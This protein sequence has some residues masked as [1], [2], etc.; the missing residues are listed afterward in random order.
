MAKPIYQEDLRKFFKKLE[1]HGSI[2]D[3]ALFNIMYWC[4]LRASEIG[5]LYVESYR[6]QTRTIRIRRLKNGISKTIALDKKRARALEKYIKTLDHP[7]PDDYLFEGYKGLP[8][9]R[10]MIHTLAK[11]YFKMAKINNSSH[12]FRHSIAVHLLDAGVSVE[13]VKAHLGHK[14]I[15]NTMKY[16]EFSAFQDRE[17]TETMKNSKYIV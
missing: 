5:L 2:R 1:T 16:C 8:I 11:K 4:G 15:N 12:A 10:Q 7:F 9:S 14:C 17:L 6:P 3:Q 13:K